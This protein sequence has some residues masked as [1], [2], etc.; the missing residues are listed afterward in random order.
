MPAIPTL[1]EK[2]ALATTL[3]ERQEIIKQHAVAGS[4][5][6]YYYRGLT[7]LAQLQDTLLSSNH[8]VEPRQPTE[9]ESKV[10]AEL[11]DLLHKYSALSSSNYHKL[12][13]RFYLLLYTLDPTTSTSYIRDELHL[14]NDNPENTSSEQQ[15]EEGEG[16]EISQQQISEQEIG[17]P[18]P[19]RRIKPGDFDPT[20]LTP[21]LVVDKAIG[22]K[23]RIA[24]IL[25]FPYL[26]EH[27]DTPDKEQQ[28][29][30]ELLQAPH[31]GDN[32][33]KVVQRLT[34][35]LTENTYSRIEQFHTG[36]LTIE[37][38]ELL[39]KTEKSPQLIENYINKL[40][41]NVDLVWNFVNTLGEEF[42]GLKAVILYYKIKE[43][44]LQKKQFDDQTLFET[45]WK[46]R[47]IRYDSYHFQV[48]SRRYSF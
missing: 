24:S 38:M 46:M 2:Y 37:Q 10:V 15:Q 1:K 22:R 6:W 39:M 9:S 31:S 35:F 26:R 8:H 45:Y 21:A 32:G 20:I 40:G 25:A 7:L 28:V 23:D 27:Y 16:G 29:L 4:D 42:N 33:E 14:F 43:L 5:D 48:K 36:N 19:A 41:D 13:A 17:T 12:R 18:K 34:R 3:E 11:Q 47:H 44:V 30:Y